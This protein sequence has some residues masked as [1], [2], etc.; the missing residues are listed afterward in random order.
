MDGSF[1]LSV[2]VLRFTLNDTNQPVRRDGLFS[3]IQ[4][5]KTVR[6][7]RS[8]IEVIVILFIVIIVIIITVPFWYSLSPKLVLPSSFFGTALVL[9]WD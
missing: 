3:F 7:A 8:V 1:V 9:F 4:K 6:S 5:I 2:W